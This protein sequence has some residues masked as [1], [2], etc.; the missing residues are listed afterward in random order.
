MRKPKDRRLW[1]LAKKIKDH[2]GQP[3]SPP[4]S[5]CVFFCSLFF[6][7]FLFIIHYIK[8]NKQKNRFLF[9]VLLEE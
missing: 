6:L 4:F 2:Q 7:L 5:S 1:K 9:V 3:S 8:S